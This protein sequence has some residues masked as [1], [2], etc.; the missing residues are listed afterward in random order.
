MRFRTM[1]LTGL[2]TGLGWFNLLSGRIQCYRVRFG[3]ATRCAPVN[4]LGRGFGRL[5]RAGCARA[6]RPTGLRRIRPEA[7]FQ[8]RNSFS[9]SN[10]FCKLQMNLNSNQI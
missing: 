9:F 8:L 7:D 10:L 3:S 2:I 5:G 4:P 6:V 1:A